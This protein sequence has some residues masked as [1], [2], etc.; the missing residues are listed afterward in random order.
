M[1]E[2]IKRGH[3]CGAAPLSH[4]ERQEQKY[5]KTTMIHADLAA[6][7]RKHKVENADKV[8]LEGTELRNFLMQLDELQVIWRRLKRRLR[9]PRV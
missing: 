9:E 4:Q 5:I 3:V 7:H 6:S 8:A 2:L 1:Q